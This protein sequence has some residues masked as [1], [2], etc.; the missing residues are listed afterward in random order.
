MPLPTK[1][2]SSFAEAMRYVRKNFIFVGAF[3]CV[4]NILMLTGPIFMLQVYDRVLSSGSVDTLLALAVLGGMLYAFM[5]L[6]EAIRSRML[7]AIG[8][9]FDAKLAG[10]AF[11]EDLAAT[12]QGGPS[13]VSTKATA[14]VGQL[15]SFFSSPAV[16]AFFDMPWMPFY[17]G[18][19]FALHFWLGIVGLVGA[20]LLI[21]IAVVSD[22]V[23]RRASRDLRAL[24][25]ASDQIAQS[26]RRNVE[27]IQGMGMHNEITKLWRRAH[28]RLL[29]ASAKSAQL[30]GVSASITKVVRLSLQSAALAVGA[31]LVIENAATGGVMIAAS[32]IM[33]KGLQPIEGA[34]Q[35][36]RTVLAAQRSYRNLKKV[37]SAPAAQDKISLP[38][39]TSRLDVDRITVL[40][41]AVRKPTLMGVNFS[42]EA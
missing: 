13:A 22:I 2:S 31:Y 42:V 28:D 17:L 27:A 40:P 10:T 1:T 16:A 4:I 19:V 39:P 26:S 23:T 38:R 5:G 11:N 14:D 34:M 29:A 7:A 41:P 25:A 12:L 30:N 21:V 6:L 18:L 9:G 15:R 8:H 3:S 24:T 32:I 37:F 35:N 20:A 33:A 36:W